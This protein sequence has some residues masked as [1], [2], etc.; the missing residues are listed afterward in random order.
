MDASFD[1]STTYSLSQSNL[2]NDLDNNSLLFDKDVILENLIE[3][4]WLNFADS[5]LTK[6]GEDLLALDADYKNTSGTLEIQDLG[7]DQIKFVFSDFVYQGDYLYKGSEIDTVNDFYTT[8]TFDGTITFNSSG[9][10]L[11]AGI[12]PD[13]SGELS[14]TSTLNLKDTEN[15]IINKELA[16]SL[17]VKIDSDIKFTDEDIEIEGPF[18][19]DFKYDLEGDDK[20]EVNLNFERTGHNTYTLD[21]TEN[22]KLITTE[23]VSPKFTL[24]NTDSTGELLWKDSNNYVYIDNNTSDSHL[25]VIKNSWS[26]DPSSDLI[27]SYADDYSYSDYTSIWSSSQSP[28]AVT[29]DEDGE[30]GN[31]G[32]YLVLI[33][34][35]SYSYWDDSYMSSPSEYTYE[36][37]RIA[38]IDSSDLKYDWDNIWIN[39]KD[40]LAQYEKVFG[41]D[42]NSD[43]FIGEPE[44]NVNDL[45]EYK[46][47]ND[48][49]I[50]TNTSTKDWETYSYLL[51]G[52]DSS[53]SLIHI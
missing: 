16:T 28:I 32:D 1:V 10:N 38:K 53:L 4:I 26:D 13:A 36:N 47:D 6:Y 35:S 48:Y 43:N 24:I 22:N 44:I 29:K 15:N 39:S 8:N 12:Y 23:T 5:E 31:A 37:W 7:T 51:P 33:G 46:L 25:K 40:E 41:Q 34:E 14:L 18:K 30:V 20:P 45:Y 27:Y 21:R 3:E 52:N 42:L 2:V 19:I 9:S 17:E 11:S 49:V 50:Y